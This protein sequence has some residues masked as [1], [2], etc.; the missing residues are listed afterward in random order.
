MHIS[1]VLSGMNITPKITHYD[2]YLFRSK[3]EAKWAV[4]FNTLKI[5]YEYEP[6][7]FFCSDGSQYTPDFHLPKSY[8]RHIDGQGF[9]LEIKA[10]YHNEPKT[11]LDRIASALECR[12]LVLLC[13]DPFDVI[14]E[15]S[16]PSNLQLSP[17]WDSDMLPMYCECCEVL[18]I[19]YHCRKNH[20]CPLCG[21]VIH[22]DRA[23]KAALIA[24]QYKFTFHK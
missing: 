24:R 22:S 3:L 1:K 6:E 9:C 23:H 20:K 8:L 16:L 4:F 2:G 12:R 11:Y 14:N 13:G 5:P 7:A 15:V 19:D 18:K 17:E 10:L 21:S